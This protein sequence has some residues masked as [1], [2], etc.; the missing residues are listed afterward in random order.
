MSF[1]QSC[2][3][4][5]DFPDI[6]VS[7]NAYPVPGAYWFA[8]FGPYDLDCAIGTGDTPL[9]AIRELLDAVEA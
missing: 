6:E 2:I 5:Q 3:P 1:P 8:T 9:D 7:E 4:V